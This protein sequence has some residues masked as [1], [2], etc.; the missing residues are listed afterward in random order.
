MSNYSEIKTYL[1]EA[2]LH[3]SRRIPIFIKIVIW[4][5]VTSLLLKRMTFLDVAR[6]QR[7]K[8]NRANFL[9]YL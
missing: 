7:G 2:A 1:I 6:V 5:E 4:P 9:K 3:R 8:N